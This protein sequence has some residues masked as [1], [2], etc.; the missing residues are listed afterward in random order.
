[1]GA[2][3]LYGVLRTTKLHF[4][5]RRTGAH[6]APGRP[7][8]CLSSFRHFSVATAGEPALDFR[9]ASVEGRLESR[10]GWKWLDERSRCFLFSLVSFTF[11]RSAAISRL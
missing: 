7:A 3:L 11:D 6:G 9:L 8:S 5:P 2:Q 4:N 1:V 10:D